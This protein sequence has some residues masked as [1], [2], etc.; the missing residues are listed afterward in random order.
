MAEKHDVA[1]FIERNGEKVQV[2]WA[3]AVNENGA[4]TFEKSAGYEDVKL[5]HVTFSDEEG[6]SEE[7]EGNEEPEAPIEVIVDPAPIESQLHPDE[8]VQDNQVT[9]VDET[10][11]ETADPTDDF[12]QAGDEGKDSAPLVV[13]HNEELAAEPVEL[14]AGG[15]IT[16]VAPEQPEAVTRKN[17][18]ENS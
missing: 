1:M 8:P 9:R 6:F 13:E 4:R 17:L 2:G 3:S 7:P 5:A 12:P 10:A 14:N 16:E 15:S 11:P 18:R